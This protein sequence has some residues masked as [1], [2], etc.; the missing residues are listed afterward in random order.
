MII[1]SKQLWA[2]RK[3][4]LAVIVVI[5]VAIVAMAMQDPI[6]QPQNYHQFADSRALFGIPNFWNVISNL[7][8]LVVGVVGLCEVVNGSGQGGLASLRWVYGMYFFFIA[9]AC[10]GSSYYHLD[11]TN[12]SLSWDRLPIACAITTFLVIV[13]GE[14]L[15]E[16]LA[17]YLLL[18]LLVLAI[19][20]VWYWYHS[21]LQGQGDLRA[22]LLVQFLSVIVIAMI[23]G[24]FPSKFSHTGYVWGVFASY[25]ISKVAEELDGQLFSVTARSISGHSI[26]HVIAALGIGLFVLALRHR[27]K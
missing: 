25:A 22:Y 17:Q 24:L 2:N 1:E 27:H 5:V 6:P 20:S 10:F 12:A 4:V 7:P 18:P 8:F 3:A 16:K 14:H 13:I 9:C 21:E 15:D 19:W 11:P 26:K 23:L